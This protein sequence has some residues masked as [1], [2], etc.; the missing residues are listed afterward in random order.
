MSEAVSLSLGACVLGIAWVIVTPRIQLR[1]SVEFALGLIAVGLAVVAIAFW[2]GDTSIILAW[3]PWAL[4]CSGGLL[5]AVSL[6]AQRAA[7]D[8]HR[9]G[10]AGQ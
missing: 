10:K 4:I 5:L 3:V 7:S 8:R 2:E 9:Y 6:V 1:L